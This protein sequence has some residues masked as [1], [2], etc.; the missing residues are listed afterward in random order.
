MLRDEQQ[1]ERAMRCA[2]T[3]QLLQQNRQLS[4]QLDRVEQ[5]FSSSAHC[6]WF[7]AAFVFIYVQLCHA[8]SMAVQQA[9]CASSAACHELAQFVAVCLSLVDSHVQQHV[10]SFISSCVGQC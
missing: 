9:L 8:M 7:A 3:D 6:S 2:S 4:Q 1:K 5:K 10:A